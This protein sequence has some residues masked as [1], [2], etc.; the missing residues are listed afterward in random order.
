MNPAGQV[1]GFHVLLICAAV[2]SA[3]RS[4]SGQ[5]G[6]PIHM[7]ELSSKIAVQN[8]GDNLSVVPSPEGAHLHCIF[9]KLEGEAT[10][11]GLWL[12]STASGADADRFRVTATSV[13]RTVGSVEREAPQ[14]SSVERPLTLNAPH[15]DVSSLA[16]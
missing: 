13:G 3:F 4:A 2:S 8:P 15:S 5:T 6:N 16:C 12:T 14:R 10:T 11:E 9:Q 1:A 7:A